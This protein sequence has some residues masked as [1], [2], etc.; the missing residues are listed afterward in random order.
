[1]SSLKSK[2]LYQLT[3]SFFYCAI[4]VIV[5]PYISRVLGPGNIG[6]VNFID[7][8]SQFFILFASFGIPFYGAREVA[9]ARN[10]KENLVSITSELLVI[11]IIFTVI[12][13]LLFGSLIF[14][15]H[16]QFND[17]TLVILAMINLI[18]SSVGLEWFIVGLENFKFLARRSFIVKIATTVSIFIFIR[19]SSDYTTYYAILVGGNFILL[20]IDA[21]YALAKARPLLNKELKIKRHLKSLSVFLLTAVTLSVYNFFDATILGFLAGT[22]AVGFYTTPLKIIRL[23]QNFIHDL[24]G[25]LLPRVSYLIDTGN[26]IEAQQLLN[27]SLQYVLTITLPLSF[28]IFLCSKEIILVL[29][30]QKF[31]NSIDVLKMLSILPLIMGLG[32]I[33]FIQVLLPFHKE[34]IIFFGVLVGCV[35]SITSNIVLCPLYAEQGAAIS[36]IAAESVVTLFLGWHATKQ[37]ELLVDLKLLAAIV[38]NCLLFIPIIFFARKISGAN[39]SVLLGSG[40]TSFLTYVLV[41]LLIFK[42]QTIAE[43]IRFFKDSLKKKSISARA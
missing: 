25:V 5:F 35:V 42:N 18:T 8:I 22:L 37:I 7:Y 16:S 19:R 40:V 29:G 39:L 33:F 4:P 30:G 10:N 26:K 12:S 36:C 21:S 11:H 20:L 1:M 14:L 31:F 43:M 13:L 17:R 41:Q 34:K 24:S 38:V 2:L 9:K 23:S 27:K 28:F 15:K 32:N 3:V 6:K